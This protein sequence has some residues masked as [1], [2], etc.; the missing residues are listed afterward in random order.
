MCGEVPPFHVNTAL[1][2]YQLLLH[3]L[4]AIQYNYQTLTLILTSV[5]QVYYSTALII[6]AAMY[7]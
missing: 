6:V 5:L 3:V 1:V 7:V 4:Q 2:I